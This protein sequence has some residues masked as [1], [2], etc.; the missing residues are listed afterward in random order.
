MVAWGLGFRLTGVEF[1]LGA[2]SFAPAGLR[3]LEVC[4]WDSFSCASLALR[5]GCSFDATHLARELADNLWIGMFEGVNER[6]AR[7][8]GGGGARGL[9]SQLRLQFLNAIP[10]FIDER[11]LGGE[12]QAELAFELIHASPRL[13]RGSELDGCAFGHSVRVE[14][15]L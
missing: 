15:S 2:G 7:R 10:S 9:R 12:R 14:S 13:G 5:G 11:F 1:G 3:H 4:W 8:R 6:F